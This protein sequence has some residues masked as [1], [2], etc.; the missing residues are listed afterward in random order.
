MY[1]FTN[2]ALLLFLMGG[3]S[4]SVHKE[5]QNKTEQQKNRINDLERQKEEWKRRYEERQKEIKYQQELKRKEE[6][7]FQDKKLLA[8]EN[9]NNSLQKKQDEKL[10]EVEK[11][12]DNLSQIWC[13]NEIKEIDFD[14]IL[15]ECFQQLVISEQLEV[16]I[17]DNIRKLIKDLIKENEI[18]HLNLQIIGKTGVGKS[19]LINTIFGEKLA[20]E[21]KGEPC[22][23]ETKCYESNKYD[24]I[25]IYDTR[26][27]EISK[28]FD[29]DKLFNE[30]FKEIKIKCENN[31][32]DEL[33]HCLIY[34]FSGT[35]FERAEGDILVKLRKTYEGKKLSIIL[36]LTQ[37]I[38]ED[39]E[40]FSQLKESINKIIEDKCEET[41]S[42]NVKRIS[43]VRVLATEKKI[44]KSITIPPKGL[45]I[46]IKKCYEKGEYTSKFACLSGIKF[47]AEKK[48]KDDYLK[49]KNDILKEKE[50]FLDIFFA[51]NFEEKIFEDI[52]EKIF[53]TFSLD[54]HR[55]FATKSTFEFIKNTNEKII[56]LIL[57]K[58]DRVFREYMEEKASKISTV[59]LDEQTL[60]GKKYEFGLG[61]CIK[62][63]G[64]F[65]YKISGVLNSRF[66]RA[67]KKN[68]IKNAARIL[69]LTITDIFMEGFVNYYINELNS[70]DCQNFLDN[71]I[72]G[73]FSSGLKDK[74]D[75]LIDDLHNYQEKKKISSMPHQ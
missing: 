8:V 49:I 27:I 54:N 28:D 55:E 61:N 22:T 56:K 63:S 2:I 9:M 1:K 26:G 43:L 75:A 13:L 48:I 70:D 47:S 20:E 32:P 46:L 44:G 31:E 60:I 15:K 33:I 38:E 62:D 65:A 6:K 35:R 50:R 11:E 16:I 39:E 18:K 71:S 3:V 7:E 14:K 42:D 4:W 24:F 12:F 58:E 57:E 66:R 41:L 37:D 73:C 30:T 64:E 19:T 10:L 36:V 34:C 51:K 59:L 5:L 52:I 74:I 29:I 72:K 23:M 21:K 45:D 67:S 69:S 25:R 53:I 17:K 68:A 40:G